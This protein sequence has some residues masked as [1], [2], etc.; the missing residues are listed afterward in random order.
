MS[1]KQIN[2]FFPVLFRLCLQLMNF[3]P[4]YFY[5]LHEIASAYSSASLADKRSNAKLLTNDMK[6]NA[7][8]DTLSYH[9]SKKNSVDNIQ[10]QANEKE[11]NKIMKNFK[12]CSAFTSRLIVCEWITQ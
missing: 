12:A 3:H 11:L 6:Q 7:V 8:R 10:K 9:D 5:I 2:S 1:N 4:Y